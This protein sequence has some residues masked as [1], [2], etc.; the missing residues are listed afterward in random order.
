M[1]GY[2]IDGHAPRTIMEALICLDEAEKDVARLRAANATLVRWKGE[3]DSHLI[4]KRVVFP[5]DYDDSPKW[6][7]AKL[8]ECGR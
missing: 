4:A 3:I 1:S 5:P 2:T 8:I 6:A 7:I